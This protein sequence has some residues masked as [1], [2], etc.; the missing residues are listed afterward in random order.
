MGCLLAS[1]LAL[2]GSGF[3][4]S[5]C[6]DTCAPHLS[7]RTRARISLFRLQERIDR[8]PA[9]SNVGHR[10]SLGVLHPYLSVFRGPMLP[11]V[12]PRSLRTVSRTGSATVHARL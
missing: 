3:C 11:A 2:S 12:L 7:A 1:L 6:P 10:R 4:S 8:G 5:T 9:I